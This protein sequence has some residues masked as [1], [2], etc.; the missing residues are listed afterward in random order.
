MKLKFHLQVAG[1]DFS[2]HAAAPY[3]VLLDIGMSGFVTESAA[4][5]AFQIFAHPSTNIPDTQHYT[6]VYQA[7]QADG[8]TLWQ[9]EENPSGH[10][11]LRCKRADQNPLKES[12]LVFYNQTDKQIA[13]YSDAVDELQHILEPLAYPVAPLLWHIAIQGHEAFMLHGSAVIHEGK[14]LVFTGFS[15]RGKSTMAGLWRAAGHTCINDDRLILRFKES[16][17]W[18]YN[19]PMPYPDD[20]K[21]APLNAIFAISHGQENEMIPQNHFD[22]LQAILPNCIQHGYDT[23][24]IE[25]RLTIVEKLCQNVP[26]YC[27]PFLPTQ[28][29]VTHIKAHV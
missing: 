23:N 12:H 20:A 22:A 29:I 27:L 24:E 13:I 7:I 2:I 9:I 11:L 25:V 6:P 21:A 15:G 18:V 26:V 19:T 4:P 8:Q 17:W 1:L 16:Q 14:A 3:K 28:D 10:K 5:N